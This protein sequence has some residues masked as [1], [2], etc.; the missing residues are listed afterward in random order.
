MKRIIAVFTMV[1]SVAVSAQTVTNPNPT[2]NEPNYSMHSTTLQSYAGSRVKDTPTMERQK[3][4]RA[5]ALRNEANKL[6]IADGGTLSPANQRY[7]QHKADAI[8]GRQQRLGSLT[9]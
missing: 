8:R 7:I 3:L 9:R 5:V 4:A 1:V 2:M 6:R